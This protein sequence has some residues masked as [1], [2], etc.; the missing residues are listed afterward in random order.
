M[1]RRLLLAGGLGLA[2]TALSGCISVFPKADPSQL[3]RFEMTPQ[4]PATNPAPPIAIQRVPTGFPRAS[5][6]DRILTMS[7]T[8]EAAYIA[9]V[10]WISPAGVMFDEQVNAA[11]VTV[12]RVR[13]IGRGDMS[14]TDYSLRLDVL[15]FETRYDNGPKSAPSVV[16]AMRCLISRSQDRQVIEDRLFTSTVRASDNRVSAIVPA[17]NKAL[18]EVMT[19]L[20]AL[21]NGLPKPPA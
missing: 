7:S 21:T 15:T 9:G 16:I 11:F 20:L 14:R 17:Y 4:A 2:A 3:Y 19:Q 8:G 13:T 1:N 5:A 10:R 6:G 12:E 18:S